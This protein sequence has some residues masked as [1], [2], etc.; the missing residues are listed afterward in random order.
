MRALCTKGTLRAD[1][2]R[3][4]S[5]SSGAEP[6]QQRPTQVCGRIIIAGHSC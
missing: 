1:P 4:K 2:A 3:Y 6:A 5:T